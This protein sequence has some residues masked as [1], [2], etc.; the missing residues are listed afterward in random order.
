MLNIQNK[1]IALFACC[2]FAI[3]CSNPLD[4]SVTEQLTARE[5]DK[6]VR[7]DKSFLTTYSIVEERWNHIH[8]AADSARWKDITYNRLHNYLIAIESSQLKSPLVVQLREKWENMYNS[9]LS[10]ADTI[11]NRWRKYLAS[12]SPDSLVSV[13]YGGI[14]VERFKNAQKQIDTLV[15]AKIT[16][17]PIKQVIDSIFISYSFTLSDSPANADSSK[18]Y[19]TLAITKKIRQTHQVKVFP[20]MSEDVKRK[21][22]AN[23]STIAFAAEVKDLYSGGKSFCK[24]S[25]MNELPKSVKL[26]FEAESA[27]DSLS[28]VFDRIFYIE[29]IIRELINS[30]FLSQS[31]YI[32]INAEDYYREIDTLVFNYINYIG[33]Q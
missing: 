6:V 18:I 29:N 11:I 10:D 1:I 19:N 14:E 33:L 12:Y 23:D 21:L 5:I 15:K 28:P 20:D 13:S 25:L 4:K 16:V 3:S 32:K 30:Q 7:K 24:D 26:Y 2:L 17:T 27:V 8:S 31:A 22:I 9:H